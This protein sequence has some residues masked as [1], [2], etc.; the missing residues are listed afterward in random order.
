MN[1]SSVGRASGAVGLD[2][3][4]LPASAEEGDA[5]GLGYASAAA[6]EAAQAAVEAGGGGVAGEE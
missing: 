4:S 3:D 5:G 6:A 1:S 2:V